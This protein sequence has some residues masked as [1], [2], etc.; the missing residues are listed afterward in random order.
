VLAVIVAGATPVD[1]GKI[2]DEAA[3]LIDI[4]LRPFDA[5]EAGR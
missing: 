2:L 4:R 3:S 5:A 1:C